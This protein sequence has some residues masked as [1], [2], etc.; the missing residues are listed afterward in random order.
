MFALLYM[1]Y[2]KYPN[3]YKR[4]QADIQNV[5][6]FGIQRIWK[7]I[8]CRSKTN[9]DCEWSDYVALQ[10]LHNFGKLWKCTKLE[11]F[12]RVWNAKKFQK[13]AIHT[14]KE[15]KKTAST[16]A[17]ICKESCQKYYKIKQIF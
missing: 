5:A 16:Y 1:Y 7:E 13:T 9:N 2:V 3:L 8:S 11:K 12:H 10:K 6:N 14:L 4:W 15:I 17:T